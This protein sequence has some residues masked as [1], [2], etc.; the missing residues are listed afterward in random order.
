[1]HPAMVECS[2]TCV[3]FSQAFNHS[4]HCVSRAG[5]KAQDAAPL[6]TSSRSLFVPATQEDNVARAQQLSSDLA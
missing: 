1:M 4:R 3:P 6:L 5:S 2:Y